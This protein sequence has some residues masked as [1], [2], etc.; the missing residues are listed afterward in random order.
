MPQVC[1][2]AG[3]G[4]HQGCAR[5]LFE[6]EQASLCVMSVTTWCISRVVTLTRYIREYTISVCCDT[7]IDG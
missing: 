5:P 3:K 2:G 4:W 6:G 1:G 7:D